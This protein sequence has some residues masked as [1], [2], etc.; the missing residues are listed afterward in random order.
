M[1]RIVKNT[2]IGGGQVRAKVYVRSAPCTADAPE[3]KFRQYELLKA[4]AET[5]ELTYCAYQPFERLAIYH[6]GYS[7]I[8]DAEAIVND[9]QGTLNA[10]ASGVTR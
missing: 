10:K 7:W 8:A 5:P 3:S 4:L 9:P 6:D 2:D 1:E